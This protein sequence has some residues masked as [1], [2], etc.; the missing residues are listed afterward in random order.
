MTRTQASEQAVMVTLDR[1]ECLRLLDLGVIGRVIYTAGA[2]PAPRP[3]NYALVGEEII[4]RTGSDRLAAASNNTVVAFE[5]DDVD[6]ETRTGWS[7]LAVG[8]AYEVSDPDR[9]PE[10]AARV[11]PPWAPGSTAH[12]IAIPTWRLTG[13]RVDADRS[14]AG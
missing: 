9:L 11:P 7:V 14:H 3:V 8:K 6:L 13:R 12:I 10:I 4:F 5:V 1:A 2:M